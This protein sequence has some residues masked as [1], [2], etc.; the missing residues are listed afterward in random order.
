M[1]HAFLVL[2]IAGLFVFVGSTATLILKEREAFADHER[3]RAAVV[4]P[5]PIPP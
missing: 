3:F 4:I 5:M 2:I 1:P